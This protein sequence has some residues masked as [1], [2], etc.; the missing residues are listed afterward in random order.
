LAYLGKKNLIPKANGVF[1]RMVGIVKGVAVV[2][3]FDDVIQFI[4]WVLLYV[5]VGQE[6]LTVLVDGYPKH[7]PEALRKYVDF[8]EIGADLENDTAPE[9]LVEPDA[10]HAVGY[11]EAAVAPKDNS[12]VLVLYVRTAGA[13]HSGDDVIVVIEIAVPI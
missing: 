10:R 12:I 6:D 5:V 2:F 1:A 13:R 3:A 8:L 4:A 7:V 9:M 11:E